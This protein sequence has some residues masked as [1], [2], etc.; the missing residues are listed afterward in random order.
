MVLLSIGYA[1]AA[2]G[3]ELMVAV[4]TFAVLLRYLTLVSIGK[5]RLRGTFTDLK[6][7][8]LAI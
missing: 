6:I 3:M 2:K 8:E 7:V 5:Q 1:K 4:L